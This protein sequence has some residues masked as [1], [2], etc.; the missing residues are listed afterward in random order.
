[1]LRFRRIVLRLGCSA[2]LGLASCTSE[3]S[4]DSVGP[5][6]P[7]SA[8]RSGCVTDTVCV[9]GCHL[10]PG[11]AGQPPYTPIPAAD[12]VRLTAEI[13][14]GRNTVWNGMIRVFSRGKT[15]AMGLKD[16][17][18]QMDSLAYPQ[19]NVRLTYDFYIEKT[20]V[21]VTQL[22]DVLDS[23]MKWGWIRIDTATDPL[24]GWVRR[25]V[26]TTGTTPMFVYYLRSIGDP[27]M[28][29]LDYTTR[30]DSGFVLRRLG[31][32][33]VDWITWHGAAL[34]ANAWSRIM[35]LEPVYDL[36][37]WKADYRRN[38]YRLPTEAET[39]FAIRAGSTT[40]Y[41]WGTDTFVHSKAMY[42][43]SVGQLNDV[44]AGGTTSIGMY[45]ALSNATEWNDGWVTGKVTTAEV[46][47]VGAETGTVKACRGGG[48][49]EIGARSGNRD[50]RSPTSG[51][52]IRLVLPKR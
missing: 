29:D 9:R 21:P 4:N 28:V 13:K 14:E 33:P 15:F 48:L 32:L 27:S 11:V 23:A 10:N 40:T 30:G 31:T 12:Y 44:K 50:A 19:H 16:S 52:G 37:T 1:M 5:T 26:Y 36:E 8:C 2:I 42:Y 7:D 45:Q 22:A 46:D 18:W 3:P 34:Y 24:N 43:G 39:E 25:K 49:S 41:F 38:G 35:G 6:P 20:E 17:L 47:P 51:A